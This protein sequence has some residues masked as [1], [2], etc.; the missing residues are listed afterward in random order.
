VLLLA[1][2]FITII[3]IAVPYKS[4]NEG[5]NVRLKELSSHNP[6]QGFASRMS[7]EY[8]IID[9]LYNSYAQGLVIENLSS[10]AEL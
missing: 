8:R 7:A 3:K 2:D 9:F 4:P 6:I 5:C 1:L 10:S